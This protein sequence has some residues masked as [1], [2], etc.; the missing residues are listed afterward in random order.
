MIL[1]GFGNGDNYCLTPRCRNL[2][3]QIPTRGYKLLKGQT[4]QNLGGVLKAGS[5]LGPNQWLKKSQRGKTEPGWNF[6]I[7]LGKKS[8]WWVFLVVELIFSSH[9][10]W[11]RGNG[12]ARSLNVFTSSTTSPAIVSGTRGVYKVACMCFNALNGSGP[13]YLSE[14][15]HSTLHLVHY[16]LLLTPAC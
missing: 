12:C 1:T 4:E 6:F 14:L 8:R 3:S 13:A 2:N 11:V 9:S 15:L 5:G 16:A 10:V 7:C